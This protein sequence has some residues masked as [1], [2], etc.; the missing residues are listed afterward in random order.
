M[1]S[2]E[3]MK[4]ELYCNLP[5]AGDSS[6]SC[7]G[8]QNTVNIFEIDVGCTTTTADD[9]TS[10]ASSAAST[11]TPTVSTTEDVVTSPPLTTAE[12]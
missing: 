6:E 4:D 3:Y 11:E 10:M 12:V 9:M 1:P 7:G 5:C 8:P 2:D